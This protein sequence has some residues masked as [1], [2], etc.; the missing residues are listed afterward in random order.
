MK[1]L[2]TTFLIDLLRGKNIA[3]L[4]YI[5]KNKDLVTT[6]I[7]MFEV[8]RGLFLKN[9]SPSRFY[10]SLAMFE[11]IRVLSL[12]NS[13]LIKSAEVS[14]NL[15]K[16]GKEIH[17]ND[18]LIAGIALSKGIKTIVTKNV[19]HFENIKDLRVENY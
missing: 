2:D 16:K 6:Q 5:K 19:K 18:C 3:V 8:I 1:V 7:N 15:I 13:A 12:D 11:N 14:A 4:D 10:K 17:D 9:V